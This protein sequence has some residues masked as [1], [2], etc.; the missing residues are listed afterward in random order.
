MTLCLGIRPT[1]RG[2]PFTRGGKGIRDAQV[3]NTV[4]FTV[5]DS[6]INHCDSD[7]V[8]ID[9]AIGRAWYCLWGYR[10]RRC[11]VDLWHP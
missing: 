3:Q 1:P 11:P 5:G 10:P 9:Q 6:P 7:L 2:P 4:H 8:V